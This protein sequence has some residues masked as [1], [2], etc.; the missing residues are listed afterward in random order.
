MFAC[1]VHAIH[2]HAASIASE[3]THFIQK[4]C[5]V[6][7]NFSVHATGLWQLMCAKKAAMKSIKV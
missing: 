2:K 1:A 5:R 3:V 6:R 4:H 7:V